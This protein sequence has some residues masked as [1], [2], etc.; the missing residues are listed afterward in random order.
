[1]RKVFLSN[2]R[3]IDANLQAMHN[4]SQT[5]VFRLNLRAFLLLVQD[6]HGIRVKDR[7]FGISAGGR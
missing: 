5:P 2:T 7:D 6:F 1:M 4:E 3:L